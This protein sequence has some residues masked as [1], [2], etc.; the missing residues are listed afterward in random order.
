MGCGQVMDRMKGLKVA[1]VLTCLVCGVETE[2]QQIPLDTIRAASVR[3]EALLCDHLNWL[4]GIRA[5]ADCQ[6]RD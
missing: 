5:V 1:N 4:E 6:V 3:A 2:V